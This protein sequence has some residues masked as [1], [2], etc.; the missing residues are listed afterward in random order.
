MALVDFRADSGSIR[1]ASAI[2]AAC[3]AALC[4]VDHA[5]AGTASITGNVLTYEAAP[6]EMNAASVTNQGSDFFIVENIA[7]LVAGP[8]C[9]LESQHSVRCPSAGISSVVV[10]L[11]DLN[12]HFVAGSAGSSGYTLSIDAGPGDDN[13]DGLGF[14]VGAV[15]HGGP[16]NDSLRGS[17][18]FSDTMFGDAGD[19][20]L[21][22][23]DS[24][25]QFQGGDDT[26]DGG[27]GNDTLLG[28]FGSDELTGGPG[29]DVAD[30]I[31]HAEDVFI[32]LDDQAND[33][34]VG[35]NDNVHADVEN[36]FGTMGAD[37]IVGNGEVNDLDGWWGDDT[38]SGG[39]GDDV[40]TAD[41]GADNLQGGPGN[42]QLVDLLGPP[43]FCLTE[44][45][46]FSGGDGTDSAIYT[47]RADDLAVTLDN[48]ANDGAPGEADNVHKDVEHVIGGAG[49]DVLT[50]S[51][52]NQTLDGW[53]GDDVLDGDTGA[54]HLIG[55]AGLDT[56]SYETRVNPVTVSLDGLAGD[57]EPGENDRIDGDV[58]IVLGG[59]AGD[60]LVGGDHRDHLYGMGGGDVI[61]GGREE[62]VLDGGAGND[63]IRSRELEG[64]ADSVSCGAD[65]DSV[66]AD[67][68][69]IV[70]SDCEHVNVGVDPPPPPPPGPPPPP[71]PPAPPP[72]TPQPPPAPQPQPPPAAAVRCRVPKVV[73]LRL[74]AAKKK[75]KKARCAVGRVRRARSS[76]VGRVVRQSPKPGARKRRGTKVSLVVGRR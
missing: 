73:G 76:R 53:D 64:F 60:H 66:T 67:S 3:L 27:D 14:S 20:T 42:D 65:D 63:S 9:F 21:E 10:T 52:A 33:G 35:E 61:D 48:V 19:D 37:V 49:D 56:V 38:I 72:P 24:T 13:V 18:R 75:I 6:G 29:M 26:L 8:G 55:G 62:D 36:V 30:Y 47:G 44:P 74:A 7:P 12:D 2:A 43:C 11:G 57:G 46:T 17:D 1:I 32:S 58:E 4:F 69:D 54:D 16:G 5:R 71:T 22:G 45:D 68:F 51:S 15:I 41:R 40:L 50:G 39:G 70:D 23:D 31:H 59:S 25:N 28:D 34:N